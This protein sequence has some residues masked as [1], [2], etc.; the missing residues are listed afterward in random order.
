VP[1]LS[2]Q[3]L[4]DEVLCEP[5]AAKNNRYDYVI[6][7][8]EDLDLGRFTTSLRP[9]FVF[10]CW[11][12]QH[13]GLTYSK[14]SASW[15]DMSLSSRLGK[16]KADRLKAQ[17][18]KSF[19]NMICDALGI[20]VAR[21]SLDLLDHEK[22]ASLEL[23][24]T[25]SSGTK[26]LLGIN[27]NAGARWKYKSLPLDQT[28][29]L[30]EL[31]FL[32]HSPINI[33]LLGGLSEFQF[34][35]MVS[36]YFLEQ[37]FVIPPDPSPRVFAANVNAC[38]I[39]LSSDSLCLHLAT[40]L[41]KPVISFFGPTSSAEIDVFGLGSKVTTPLECRCCYKNDCDFDPNCMDTLSLEQ[42]CDELTLFLQKCRKAPLN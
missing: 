37:V 35:T 15:F 39:V 42:L 30:I 14:T 38:D 19:P 12:D 33:A 18:Q 31:I 22:V 23:K 26:P 4:I 3:S 27:A 41:H 2:S 40:A 6:N 36:Q 13:H 10:G 5:Q 17:N 8:E 24:K 28:I 9:K 21:P 7:L 29:K 34:N 32:H 1:L 25:L 11:F 16:E 20:S